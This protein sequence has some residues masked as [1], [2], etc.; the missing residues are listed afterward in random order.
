MEPVLAKPPRSA[1]PARGNG[2]ASQP[3]REMSVTRGVNVRSQ[4]IIIY[5]P[6]GVG[7]SSLAASLDTLDIR[8]LFIDLD[9]GSGFLD[10]TR[11]D[12]KTFAEMRSILQNRELLNEY[13]AVVVDSLTRAEELATAY[14]LETVT[15]DKG[16]F[17]KSV[18]G[19][20]FGK[21]YQYVFETMLLL[22]NELDAVARTGKHIICIAHE[23]VANV[24][25][26]HGEDFIRFEPRLQS[27]SS[28]K[29]SVR[30]R[31]KEWADHLI[32]IG[33][34]MAVEDG[35]A[36]GCGSRTMTSKSLTS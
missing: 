25:N 14:T 2:I 13:D 15:N 23:C 26:P 4:K 6:G 20:G 10:V 32:F 33:F 19:Y 35:K 27:P 22:L 24:P 16:Q 8:T 7:K 30:L 17:V 31:V 36:T 28:G 3:T 11:T 5:G 34:D 9:E 21:G 29:S 18:E 1:P 12:P